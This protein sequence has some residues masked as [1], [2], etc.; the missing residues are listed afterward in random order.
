MIQQPNQP[1]R[2]VAHWLNVLA[3]L[4]IRSGADYETVRQTL[5][6]IV[7]RDPKVAAANIARNRQALLK[8]EMKGTAGKEVIKLGT[9]EQN[10]G[11]KQTR[12]ESD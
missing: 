3:D 5:Q 12:R 11:L 10:I 9:Y 2:L 7:D 6:R 4:Q 8:L 1:A